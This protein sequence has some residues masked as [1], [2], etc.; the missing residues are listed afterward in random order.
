MS[1]RVMIGLGSNL[2]DRRE[3]LEAAIRALGDVPGIIVHRVSS[4][5]ETEPVGG[6]AGQGMYLNAAAALETRLDPFELLR[7]LQQ[8]EARFGRLRTVRWGARTLD[9]DLLLYQDRI[10]D[11]PELKVPHPRL[12][13]RRFVLEPLAEIAPHAVEPVSKRTIA[14][15]LLDLG[16]EPN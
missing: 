10:I 9:L 13:S 7:A 5:R 4:F 1:S 2:G 11:T 3:T 14:E 16:R 12:A 15:L 8:I 6:P